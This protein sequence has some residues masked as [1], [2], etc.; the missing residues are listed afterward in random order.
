M[1]PTRARL[2]LVLVFVL[3]L[4]SAPQRFWSPFPYPGKFRDNFFAHQFTTQDSRQAYDEAPALETPPKRSART[5]V[6][7]LIDLLLQILETLPGLIR[8]LLLKK[9]ANDASRFIEFLNIYEKL[10]N[11]IS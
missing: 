11:G 3:V 5:H 7:F 2:V 1:P 10:G 9:T 4:D 8:N 6:V